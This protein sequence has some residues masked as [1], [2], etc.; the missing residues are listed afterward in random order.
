MINL[1]LDSFLENRFQESGNLTARE[2]VDECGF[3][4]NVSS[5]RKIE[6]RLTMTVRMTTRATIFIDDE[7]GIAWGAFIP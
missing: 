6:E 1:P 7:I 3:Q 4:E 5:I 2:G